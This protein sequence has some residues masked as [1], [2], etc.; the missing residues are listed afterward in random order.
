MLLVQKDSNELWAVP[1]ILP[2][3]NVVY[4][5]GYFRRSASLPG[6]FATRAPVGLAMHPFSQSLRVGLLPRTRARGG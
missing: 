4:K 1:P 6:L 3:T 5:K 2:H